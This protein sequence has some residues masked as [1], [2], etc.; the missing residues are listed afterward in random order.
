VGRNV[1]LNFDDSFDPKGET[2]NYGKFT[3]LMTVH[4]TTLLLKITLFAEKIVTK[5]FNIKETM[6]L[7]G[8][9]LQL[10]KIQIMIKGWY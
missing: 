8:N 4:L 6:W 10:L 2:I 1:V 7:M 9:F 5:R 3:E